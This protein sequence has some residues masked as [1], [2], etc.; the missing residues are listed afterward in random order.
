[1]G[2]RSR[3]FWQ[4][5]KGFSVKRFV[6]FL[7]A[8]VFIGVLPAAQVK[9]VA[10][11]ETEMDVQSGVSAELAA[12][13][14]RLVT[15]VLRKE[16]AK[17]LPRGKYNI[18]TSETV[19]SQGSA[20]LEEC[21]DE[22]CVIALGSKIGADYIVRGII[23]KLE[24]MLT[25]SVEIYE[26]ENGNLVDASDL[27]RSRNIAEL[28]EKAE[29][30]CANM[31]R[32]FANLPNPA[33]VAQGYPPQSPITYT[34]TTAA[35]PTN[36]G[37]VSRNPNQTNYAPKTRVSLMAVPTEG[38]KFIGW[39]GAAKGTANPITITVDGDKMLTANFQQPYTLTTY[40]FPSDGGYVYRS[41]DKETYAAG[42]KVILTAIS[43]NGYTFTGWTGA[44]SGR[45][46]R[47][48]VTMDGDKA[49]SANFYQKSVSQ[50]VAPKPKTRVVRET[51]PKA[52]TYGIGGSFASDFGGGIIWNGSGQRVTMPY[53]GWGVHMFLDFVYVEFIGGFSWGDGMWQSANAT[54]SDD[55]PNMLRHY[56]SGGIFLKYSFDI[57]PSLRAT[58]LL[59]I[60]YDGQGMSFDS[61]ATF[62]SKLEYANAD[63]YPFDGRDG[64]PGKSALNALW[65]KAGVG[66]DLGG[67][68]LYLRIEALYGVRMVN[69]F[70]KS[71]VEKEKRNGRDA[72]AIQ[73]RGLTIRFAFGINPKG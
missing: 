17:N 24:T 66:I 50:Y 70:E 21:A 68:D 26:T 62:S 65:G 19:Y 11:V 33:S 44:A 25:L 48:T 54:E 58:P 72:R 37:Y 4:S 27:I 2:G 13:D 73:G 45:K 9:N 12:S 40:V 28:I 43:A 31:Y 7:V 61:A 71:G 35:N 34:I 38:C 67:N 52:L 10:V 15:A 59:G 57:G 60:D 55:L 53:Y 51:A 46:N 69:D 30:V 8:A 29:V 63:D 1:M 64:R 49:L 5:S 56:T 14:V 16:A 3:Y 39:S 18:M 36:G 6:C 41:P 23:S 32:T 20:V 22:N 47:L 42:E